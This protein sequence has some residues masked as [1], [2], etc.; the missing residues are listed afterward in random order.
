LGSEAKQR[1]NILRS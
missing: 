1:A